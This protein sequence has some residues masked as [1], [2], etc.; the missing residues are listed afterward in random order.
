M[1]P[2]FLHFSHISLVHVITSLLLPEK[3]V[4]SRDRLDAEL[5]GKLETLVSEIWVISIMTRQEEMS[6]ISCL[7]CA[8][9]PHGNNHN[10]AWF[11]HDDA[12]NWENPA[13]WTNR[14]DLE[15]KFGTTNTSISQ[16]VQLPV[17]LCVCL[18]LSRSLTH[19][20]LESSEGHRRRRWPENAQILGVQGKQ[21]WVYHLGRDV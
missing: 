17:S 7:F 2:H 4:A 1:S 8:M 15:R 10:V 13:G 16:S 6:L 5:N 12:I 3:I 21:R 19:F 9:D 18:S 20:L 11:H 14:G